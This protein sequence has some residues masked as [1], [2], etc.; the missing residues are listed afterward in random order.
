VQ[1]VEDGDQREASEQQVAG[2]K[3]LVSKVLTAPAGV[4]TARY[5]DLGAW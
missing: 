2:V 4:V 5:V 1:A 3:A